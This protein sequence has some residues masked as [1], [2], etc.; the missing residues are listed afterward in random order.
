MFVTRGP[1]LQRLIGGA[2]V[3]YRQYRE[4]AGFTMIADQSA[5]TGTAE[6]LLWP[7][8]FSFEYRRR[9][10]YQASGIEIN[11]YRCSDNAGVCGDDDDDQRRG[12]RTD[13][14]FRC[15][16]GDL[17]HVRD[18]C[19]FADRGPVVAQIL[20]DRSA[21]FRTPRRARP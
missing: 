9:R 15:D 1:N 8:N 6:A 17:K 10:W 13:N 12:R 2:R 5:V 20:G 21:P 4:P 18:R 16:V 11:A 3:Y 7:A 19:C 14:H